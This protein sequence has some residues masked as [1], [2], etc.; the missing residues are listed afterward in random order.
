MRRRIR[1]RGIRKDRD[2]FGLTLFKWSLLVYDESLFVV[3][4]LVC[5]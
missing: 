2:V 3:L 1:I 4:E 5:C